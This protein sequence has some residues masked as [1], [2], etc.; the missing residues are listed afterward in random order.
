MSAPPLRA[1]GPRRYP[2]GEQIDA[3]RRRR[4]ARPVL[5]AVAVAVVALAY[6]GAGRI[7]L[8]L[9]YLDGA[10][11]ALWP[12]AGLGLAVLFLYG[13][14]LWPAIVIGDLML[15]DYSTPL[16]TVLAQTLGNTLALV[17][18]ASTREAAEQQRGGHERDGVPERLGEHR[19]ERRRVVGQQQIADHDRG[20]QADAV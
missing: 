5:Y 12:P 2:V 4:H 13:T 3:L 7:G 20:P 6:Y 9:A 1:L 15:G 18:A 11:A 19:P 17:A 10:V 16:G 14:R 8:R